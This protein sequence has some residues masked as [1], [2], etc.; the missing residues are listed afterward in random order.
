ML[1]LMSSPFE[2]IVKKSAFIFTPGAPE[3]KL[4]LAITYLLTGRGQGQGGMS[5]RCYELVFV[6]GKK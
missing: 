6:V 4:Q 3:L 1:F 2:G 5:I